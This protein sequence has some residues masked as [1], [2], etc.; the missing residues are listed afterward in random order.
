MNGCHPILYLL[1]QGSVEYRYGAVRPTGFSLARNRRLGFAEQN[2]L[3]AGERGVR[4]T[5]LLQNNPQ[6][7]DVRDN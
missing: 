6:A 5:S 3:P 2:E 7:R 4:E 1:C